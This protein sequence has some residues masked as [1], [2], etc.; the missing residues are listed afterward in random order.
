[1]FMKVLLPEPEG[2]MTATNSPGA[3]ARLDPVER[4]HLDLAHLVDPDEILDPNDVGST[5]SE[6]PAAARSSG[7]R[8]A[9]WDCGP[10]RR[11]LSP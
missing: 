2:P 3:I 6:S 8:R 5:S 7:D 9:P 4:P 10:R 11:R 1:M